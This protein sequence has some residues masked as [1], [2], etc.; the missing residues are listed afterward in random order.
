MNSKVIDLL[1]Y[2]ISGYNY[3]DFLNFIS[4]ID[5]KEYDYIPIIVESLLSK[6]EKLILPCNAMDICGTGGDVKSQTTNISTISAFVLA[7][8][9]IPVAKHGGRSVS[10]QSGSMDFLSAMSI[11]DC[12]PLQSIKKHNIC[13]LDARKY[14]SFFKNIAPFRKQ[15]GKPT[16]FNMLGPLL[17]PATIAHQMVGI[18]FMNLKGYAKVLDRLGRQNFAVVQSCSGADELLSFEDNLMY[19]RGGKTIIS[20]QEYNFPMSVDESIQ[21]GTPKENA[22]MAVRFFENPQENTLFY[23]VSLNCGVASFVYGASPTIQAGIDIAMDTILQK[24]PLNI[25]HALKAVK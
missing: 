18:S 22:Y 24:K 16:I 12:D 13:F 19:T 6:G 1:S 9:G 23:T 8:M 7:S 3:Q 11:E 21:G 17:N 2:A 5:G 25:L 15:Y 10:S 20:P 14:H 4:T